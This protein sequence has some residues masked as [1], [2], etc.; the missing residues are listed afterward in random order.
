[1]SEP[2]ASFI[3]AHAKSSTHLPPACIQ[4]SPLDPTCILL[5]T[6]LLDDTATTL[7]TRK[8]GTIE[9][10]KY[11]ENEKHLEL[12]QTVPA[13][14]AI[15]DLKFSPHSPSTIAIATTLGCIHIYTLSADTLTVSPTPTQT[16][17][18]GTSDEDLILSLNFSPTNPTE[19]AFTTTA[20]QVGFVDIT[21]AEEARRWDT[22]D[23][24]AWTCEYTRDGHGLYSGGDDSVI[25]FRDLRAGMESWR[26]RKTHGAGVTA[27]LC[28]PEL[29][30]KGEMV[31]GSYDEVVRVW[32]VRGVRRRV[33]DE[34][35]VGGG[36]WRVGQMGVG[37]WVVSG[38]QA[39]PRVVRRGEEGGLEVVMEWEAMNLNYG[40]AWME[41]RPERVFW[42]SF[43]DKVVCVDDVKF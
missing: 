37:M 35:G 39:G 17:F 40:C 13:P 6:Y 15:L 33:V 27:V 10:W 9:R 1:M 42:C 31:S 2:L 43:Y 22:H 29:E 36:A 21:S 32:D 25:T 34:V 3:T 7:Q 28:S 20:G 16:L 24:E 4:I 30:A 14:G 11:H 41:E 38:M 26:D 19:I 18:V 23:L 5:G 12:L 8:T